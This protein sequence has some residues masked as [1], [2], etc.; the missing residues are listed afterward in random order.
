M[1]PLNEGSILYMP[2]ALP[3]MS[4]GEATRVLQTMDRELKKFPEVE[5]VF[6]KVGRSTSPTDPAP[7]SM[8][9]TNVMLKPVAEW[10]EGMTWDKLIGEMDSAM[11]FPGMP[12]IWWMPIQTR[13]EMLATGIRSS[14]GIK[15]FGPELGTI[16]STA[17]E[18]ERALLADERT[19]PHTRSAFA[20]RA[21][22]GYFLDF[23]IDRKAAARFGLNVGDVQTVIEAAMG[24]VTV[25]ET[26]EGRER[27]GILVRYAREYRDNIEA[28]KRVFVATSTGAQIPITQVAD[29]RFRTGP[30]ALRNEDGQLVSFVFVDVGDDIGIADYVELAQD[31]VGE[32]V[33][34]S[35]GY[36][37]DWA[38]Q[39]TY[40]ERAKA[41]LSVLVPLTIFVIFFML[42][43]HRKSLTETLIVMTALPFSL[44]GSIW[45]LSALGY[46]LSV[47]VAVG[48]IAVAGLAVELGLLMMLYLDIAYRRR[49]DE[50]GLNTRAD[51]TSAITDGASQ[52]I[53][54]MLMTGLA[55]FMGLVPI[56]YSS[57]S[58]ADVMK[59]IAAPMLGGIGSAL[60]LVL[61]A[62]PA[63]FSFW[64]GRGLNTA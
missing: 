23:D 22:G 26:V 1:P 20:E 60:V 19:A 41:R 32:K 28:L 37:I 6:G 17:V 7:L 9:E 46:N 52:R 45:L 12:N 33:E 57:G 35:P 3:G 54:P 42:Y 36:R 13:T 24:G 16:E 4:I 27:Y 50:G 62:F 64:R 34:I 53:R 30:P 47:A 43:L 2:T 48:M 11:R 38:G 15:V 10:R 56:M 49:L 29:I 40:F 25:S 18:I 21:T 51:L 14:L 58:G 59:R 5:R 55:L 39:F 31:V 63:I 8:I 44:I 61:I